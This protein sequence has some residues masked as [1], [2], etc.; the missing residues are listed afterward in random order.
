MWI[1]LVII[2]KEIFVCGVFLYFMLVFKVFIVW[3]IGINKL[4]LKFVG[5]F[6]M[7]DIIC[8]KFMFVLMFLCGNGLYVFF[9][10]W[11]NLENIKF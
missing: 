9:G 3:M 6:W 5:V 2:L 7:I 11:L 10:V 8:F 1:W 4:V